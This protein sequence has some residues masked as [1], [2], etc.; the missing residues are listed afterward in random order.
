MEYL[1][2]RKKK[3]LEF[4]NSIFTEYPKNM[5]I[6][7]TNHCNDKCIFCDNRKMTRKRGFI[8][9]EFLNRILKEAYDLGTREVGFY[10][11][12]EPLM[13]KELPSYIEKAKKI[14]YEYI[15]ITTNGALMTEKAIEQIVEAGI[16]SIK[17]SINAGTK[18]TY[19]IIHNSDDFFNVLNNL[20]K[21]YEYR[22][23]NKKNFK[24]FVSY[25]NTKQNKAE[26]SIL[27][28]KILK[29]IDEIED[30]DVY[31]Q[32]GS[33]YEINGIITISND[34]RPIKAPCF[35]LFNR[36]HIT[37]EG[38]LNICCVDFQNYLAVADLNEVSIKDAWN[39]NIFAD[40]RKR[41]IENALEGTMCYNCVNNDNT[42]IK[43]LVEK[44]ATMINKDIRKD[45]GLIKNRLQYKDDENE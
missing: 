21:L 25:V 4:N 1:A 35:M 20:E 17:F 13:C 6:E 8:D 33:M 16:D 36:F 26:L 18:E 31:N 5:L 38:Y 42:E 14:G 9:K 27:K 40:I 34:F 43:P 23:N 28:E 24:I 44:Y 29:Y 10:T 19:K 11:T 32:G 3:S 15:Y 12:G 45:I 41:H 22:K 37:Y 39:C 30:F 2:K 7:V